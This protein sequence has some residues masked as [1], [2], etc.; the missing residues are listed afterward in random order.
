MAI[1]V[2][3]KKLTVAPEGLSNL[4]REFYCAQAL[5]HRNIVKVYEMDRDEDVAFLTME[6]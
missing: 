4:Q 5:S 6:Y 1:K 3:H 2:L